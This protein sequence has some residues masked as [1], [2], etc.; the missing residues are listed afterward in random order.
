VFGRVIA[1]RSTVRMIEEA[2]TKGDKPEESIVIADCG[3][4][5]PVR[6]FKFG[7]GK[8]FAFRDELTLSLSFFSPQ[9]EPTG[10]QVADD[11]TGDTYEEHPSDDEADV[12]DPKVSLKIAGELRTIGTK[13]F[14]GGEFDQANKKCQSGF[15]S[16]WHVCC[17][18][19]G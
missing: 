17:L 4:L 7:G 13:L 16:S 5:A 9:G 8:N 19:L 12:H 14:K 11:G 15:F 2:P 1:G 3:E 18:F 6:P 10:V